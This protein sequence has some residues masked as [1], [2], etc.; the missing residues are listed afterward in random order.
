MSNHVFYLICR[1]YNF[2]NGAKTLSLLYNVKVEDH[3]ILKL[4]C[5]QHS[6]IS[7]IYITASTSGYIS[8]VNHRKSKYLTAVSESNSKIK[9][10]YQ[11]PPFGVKLHQSGINALDLKQITGMFS[12]LSLLLLL[13]SSGVCLGFLPRILFL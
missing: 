12:Y 2:D 11:K 10:C 1:V 6:E 5:I 7:L 9:G 4:A 13:L 8:F 3:C